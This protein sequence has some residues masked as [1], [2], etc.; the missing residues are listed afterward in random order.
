[1]KFY[2]K[3]TFLEY[4][5]NIPNIKLLN[6]NDHIYNVSKLKGKWIFLDFWASWCAPCIKE[7]PE[8]KR[9]Y[10]NYKMRNFEIVGISI[11]KNKEQWLKS[12]TDYYLNW[13]NLNENEIDQRKI[14][15]KLNIKGIPTNF[16]INP[17]GKIILKN[18]TLKDLE[19]FLKNVK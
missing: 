14:T 10:D 9:I 17:E 1:M 5:S 6:E 8:L 19:D 16:L 3:K 13:I 18:V 11:D 4:G 12:I 7:F 2:S 15:D